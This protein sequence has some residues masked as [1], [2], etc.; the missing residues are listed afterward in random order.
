MIPFNKSDALSL[1][2]YRRNPVRFVRDELKGDPSPDQAELLMAC[3]DLNN[4]YFILSAGRGAGKTKVVSWVVSWAMACLPD[5]FEK[6]DIIILGGSEEQSRI[7]YDYFYRDIFRTKYLEGRL[8]DNP[9]MMK[10]VFQKGTVRAIPAS[11]RRIRGPHPEMLLLDEVCAADDTLVENALPMMS[12]SLHGRVFMLSTPHKYFGIFQDY[13]DNH[14]LYEY[15]QFGPWPLT[16]CHWVSK[17]WLELMKIQMTPAKYLVEILGRFPKAGALVF[18]ADWIDNCVA[19]EPFRLNP[20]YDHDGGI[21]WGHVNPSVLVRA[22]NIT[23]KIRFPGPPKAWQYELFPKIQEELRW[24]Y[25]K[26]RGDTYY[27]DASHIG[28]NQRMEQNGINVEAIVFS[29]KNKPG[30][31]ELLAHLLYKN[32]IEISPDNVELITQLKKYKWEMTRTGK[33]KLTKTESD[34]VEAMLLSMY[35]LYDAG[36]L[37]DLIGS[38]EKFATA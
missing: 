34:Y 19:K 26:Q 12:G 14:K 6:Y 13:W 8:V 17:R 23:G 38:E 24:S 33:E 30:M 28:E 2:L 20:N 32:L 4:L 31:A 22:Q 18:N 10:T 27:A 16:K 7:M 25:H 36:Y 29:E 37:N 5:L 11:E 35:E 3:A 1:A 21:D 15:Q 9:S